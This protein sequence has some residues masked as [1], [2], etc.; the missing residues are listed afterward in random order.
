MPTRGSALARW[1]AEVELLTWSLIPE[2]NRTAQQTMERS[3]RASTTKL[4]R[5]GAVVGR[6]R[7]GAARLAG[8]GWLA[9]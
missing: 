6:K 4:G 1:L 5:P 8:L 3:S 9:S 2:Q 7:V